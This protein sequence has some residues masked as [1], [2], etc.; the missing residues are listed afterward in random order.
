MSAPRVQRSRSTGNGRGGP[1]TDPHAAGPSSDHVVEYTGGL[2]FHISLLRQTTLPLQTFSM[3]L[4]MQTLD[5]PASWLQLMHQWMLSFV[6]SGMFSYERG[7]REKNGHLQGVVKVHW[8]ADAHH[9]KLLVRC[10][11]I[12]I[13]K[14]G[15]LYTASAAV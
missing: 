5:V 7:S 14:V 15:C 8:P 4:S 1:W 6:V 10:L 13:L 12:K 11:H 2:K 9:T 3:T